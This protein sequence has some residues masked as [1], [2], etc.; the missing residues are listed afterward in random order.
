MGHDDLIFLTSPDAVNIYRYDQ[1]NGTDLLSVLYQYCKNN[2]NISAAAKDA[3]MHRNTFASRL[4][5]IRSILKDVDINDGKVQHRLLF[6]CR[7]FRYYNFYYDKKA[8]RS[9]SER[10]SII[11]PKEL[12][13]TE[14]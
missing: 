11:D 2:G 1:Q 14:T 8:S 12:S 10:L 7:V 6:S 13:R 3:Y 9:L 5:E 4:A